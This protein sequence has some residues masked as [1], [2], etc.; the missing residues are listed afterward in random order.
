METKHTPT[1][2]TLI[3]YQFVS[4]KPLRARIHGPGNEPVVD[5]SNPTFDDAEFIVRACNCHGEL[6]AVAE[7]CMSYF[8][9]VGGKNNSMAQDLRAVLAKATA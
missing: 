3:P 9:L 4:G 5:D 8:E 2:Y 1:P 6:V 7:R